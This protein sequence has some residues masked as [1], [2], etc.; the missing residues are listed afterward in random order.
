MNAEGGGKGCT[1]TA[2]AYRSN[3]NVMLRKAAR[4]TFTLIRRQAEEQKARFRAW[5]FIMKDS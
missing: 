5:C 4:L 1:H 3:N 2:I